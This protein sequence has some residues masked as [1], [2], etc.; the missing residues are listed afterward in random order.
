MKMKNIF[1]ILLSVLLF[2][3]GS[4]KIE[5]NKWHK[6]VTLKT[7]LANN[8][9]NPKGTY[10]VEFKFKYDK[11]NLKIRA[12][13]SSKDTTPS[14]DFSNTSLTLRANNSDSITFWVK[15]LPQ[16]QEDDYSVVL[17]DVISIH[18]EPNG[19][20]T[21]LPKDIVLDSRTLKAGDNWHFNYTE[22]L[23]DPDFEYNIPIQSWLYWT[24]LIGGIVILLTVL[25]FILKIDNM[26]LGKQTFE[27]GRFAFNDP[28]LAMVK[29][30]DME[31][32]DL[33]K[34]LTG[35]VDV[36]LKLTHKKVTHKKKEIKVARLSFSD[37]NIRI[38]VIHFDVE[39]MA[40][41]GYQLFN[42]DDLII[43]LKKDNE[44]KNFNITYFN[45]KNR[46]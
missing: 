1:Y 25:F 39:E 35:T 44:N 45:N 22:D 24:L 11:S 13:D 37:P 46:R 2:S 30:A 31:E 23:Y 10:Q 27:N 36:N 15:I 26:P 16:A 6:L 21:T 8:L 32:F 29:L 3:C 14:S 19:S 20:I 41:S 7:P 12:T 40:S 42:N 34:H 33:G 43:T 5:D 18:I 9:K 4:K 38:K 28:Q 17:T